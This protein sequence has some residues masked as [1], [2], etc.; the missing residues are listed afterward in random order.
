VYHVVVDDH[1]SLCKRPSGPDGVDV[2]DHRLER[3]HARR[4]RGSDQV[5]TG[6]G[7]GSADDPEPAGLE[8]VLQ[9]GQ[10][11][12]L[13]LRVCRRGLHLG[14]GDQLGDHRV[15]VAS[16]ALE[17]LLGTVVAENLTGRSTHGTLL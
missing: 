3:S 15:A 12:L 10:Q 8:L 17:Q 13:G 2:P 4:S 7:A 1:R 16:C 5:P 9:V 11:W 6:A 14:H